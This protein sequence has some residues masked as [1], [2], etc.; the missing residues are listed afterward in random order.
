[1]LTKVFLAS[2]I[3]ADTRD[4]NGYTALAYASTFG[5]AEMIRTLIDCGA[6]VDAQDESGC[7]P[8][9]HAARHGLILAF[10]RNSDAAGY[11]NSVIALIER[12]ADP[13]F[14]DRAGIT[15]LMYAVMSR[16]APTIKAIL[17]AGAPM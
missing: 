16:H 11:L 12:G 17:A 3:G 7:T 13:N 14:K 4:N 1:M 2:G 8:L 9:M 5:D 6:P 15:P 10:A